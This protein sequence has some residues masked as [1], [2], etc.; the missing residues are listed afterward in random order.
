MTAP[1][2]Q[3]RDR[4]AAAIAGHWPIT[5][6]NDGT[7]ICNCGDRVKADHKRQAFREHTADAVLATVQ[8]E[9]DRLQAEVAEMTRCRDAALRA[10]HRDDI[11]TDIDIEEAITDTLHGPGWDW[12]DERMPGQIAREVAPAI[13][14][15]LAKATQQ[16]AAVLA[17]LPA[18]PAED[19][20]ASWIPLRH[21]RAAATGL[22]VQE[23]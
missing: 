14:P 19:I 5:P 4:I 16:L 18:D 2:D 20:N 8:T 3:L 7:V 9:L 6:N 23:S 22:T 15:A 12:E 11:E 17:L 13:R 10:L 21:I 1:T